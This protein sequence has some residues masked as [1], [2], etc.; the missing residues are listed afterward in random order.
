[1]SSREFSSSGGESRRPL[2]SSCCDSRRRRLRSSATVSSSSRP[3]IA[4]ESSS[5]ATRNCSS[6]ALVFRPRSDPKR[7]RS[8][9]LAASRWACV[10]CSAEISGGTP[11]MLI[12][13]HRQSSACQSSNPESGF[14]PAYDHRESTVLTGPAGK[15]GRKVQGVTSPGPS[16]IVRNKPSSPACGELRISSRPI[17][18]MGRS[19]SCHPM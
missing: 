14:T 9:A 8:R 1:M 6:S 16:Q 7:A 10:A 5:P 15:R 19:S 3:R 18:I 13:I 11:E 12:P 17:S 2:I 4:A